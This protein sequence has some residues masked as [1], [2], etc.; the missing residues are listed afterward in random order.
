MNTQTD[1][2]T[3]DALVEG[4]I[5]RGSPENYRASIQ[6]KGLSYRRDRNVAS[7]TYEIKRARAVFDPNLA[8]GNGGWRCPVGTRR[9]G[10]ITNRFGRG[11]GW[12]AARRLANAISDTGERLETALDRGRERRVN[13]RNTRMARRL[14]KPA[15]RI[16]SR[17][18]RGVDAVTERDRRITPRT[19]RGEGRPEALDRTADEVLEGSFLRN[20]RAR[21][22]AREAQQ[23]QQAS[24]PRTQ[25][26]RR[27]SNAPERMD[28]AANE[29]LEG[30]FLANRRRRR[31][32]ARR[33]REQAQ[34]QRTTPS[35]GNRRPS[36]PTTP[37]GTTQRPTRRRGP[38]VDV[39][40][41]G[42]DRRQSADYMLAMELNGIIEYWPGRLG[43]KPVTK[44]NIRAY[45]AER[46]QREGAA[47]GYINT[48]RA[49][50]RDWL[51]LT[52]PNPHTK[53]NDLSPQ[54]RKRINEGI[55][56][57]E[58]RDR[59]PSR[60]RTP[61]NPTPTPTPEAPETPK[62]PKPET[63][64]PEAPAGPR[65][66]N[67]RVVRLEDTSDDIA[68]RR[69]LR[70]EVENQIRANKKSIEMRRRVAREG[71]NIEQLQREQN[72][73]RRRHDQLVKIAE[74]KDNNVVERYRQHEIARHI[75]DQ[76][77]EI[78]GDIAKVKERRSAAAEAANAPEAPSAPST[79]RT[80]DTGRRVETYGLSKEQRRKIDEF[81]ESDKR[82]WANQRS[83]IE[84]LSRGN[85]DP[86]PLIGRRRVEAQRLLEDYL[87]FRVNENADPS[88]RYLASQ[89]LDAL[90]E[91][92]DAL[93]AMVSINI[94]DE[95]PSAPTT[96]QT[97]EP[98]IDLLVPDE[99]K[100]KEL[101]Q[102]FKERKDAILEKRK[103]VI[104]KY[105]STRYGSGKAPWK[106][107]T[108]N[109]D[110]TALS[111]LLDDANGSDIQKR[112]AARTELEAWAKSIYQLPE[113]EGKDGMKFQTA[114]GVTVNM[115]SISV[116]GTIQAY[117]QSTQRWTNI[118][119]ISRTLYIRQRITGGA[120]NPDFKPYVSNGLLKIRSA[121][122]KNS[123]FASIYNPHAFT[124]LKASGFE[125]ASVGTMWDGKFV[126]GKMGYRESSAKSRNLALRLEAEVK[127]IRE[128]GTSSIINKRDAEII[129]ALIDEARRKNFD[130]RAPQHAEYLMAM[131]NRDQARV[132]GWFT[133]NAPFDGGKFYFDEIVD[134][135]RS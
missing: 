66:S 106:D 76:I 41:A 104:G 102:K 71:G 114:V 16:A 94:P 18:S 27:G 23:G 75:Q 90:R 57:G 52:G 32:A 51:I 135:P 4:R 85:E 77:M 12:G 53:V 31:E 49:R 63:P 93:D 88:D 134:D 82:S 126:W 40:E 115:D 29:V 28:E 36:G 13:R 83:E 21:R 8:D 2:T 24:R 69:A 131:S 20:R 34:V 129:A 54:V 65:T 98:T 46:E 107:R 80:P 87:A 22:A 81:V 113:F 9:G 73:L 45:V 97:P 120:N 123:G 96:P 105:M 10:T 116:S 37:A 78:D 26:Q 5:L 108:K 68:E 44:E 47:P 92:K 1:E 11:C 3:I 112:N 110:I 7:M 109:P 58:G 70:K 128:G 56:R 50:E 35:G 48:L 38:R 127:K 62:K 111:G 72:I 55:S 59:R 86:T 133:R 33:R 103:K 125:Y 119:D 124:W 42:S 99:A 130:V 17:A 64:E 84:R 91:H 95:T 79:P 15:E 67:R 61:N 14:G 117:N 118:G 60:P 132:K 25:R 89:S 101:R 30:S 100:Q 74:N 39:G 6:Y 122:Y 121:G 43:N 19:R